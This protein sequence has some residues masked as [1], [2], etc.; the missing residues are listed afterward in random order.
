MVMVVPTWCGAPDEGECMLAPFARLGTLLANS[1]ITTSYGD[2]LSVF[3]P[4]LANG[5][6]VLMET[7]WVPRL[8]TRC[9]EVLIQAMR[10]SVSTR[11]RD[12]SRTSSKAQPRVSRPRQRR[13]VFA[14][15]MC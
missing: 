11:L 8:D 4:F 5:Q 13:S 1:V 2:S 6:R 3:D 10:R 14:A 15:I 9:N 7:C 12:A